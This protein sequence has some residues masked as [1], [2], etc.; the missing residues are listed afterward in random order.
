VLHQWARAERD[1]VD[2]A[3]HEMPRSVAEGGPSGTRMAANS[4]GGHPKDDTT[5]TSCVTGRERQPP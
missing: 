5:R 3:G 2:G 1:A 4:A